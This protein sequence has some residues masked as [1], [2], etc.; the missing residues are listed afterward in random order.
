MKRSL[1]ALVFGAAAITSACT[2][3]Q[4]YQRPAVPAP[5][6]WKTEAPWQVAAPKDGI[7][8]GAWWQTFQ[9][10]E[11]NGYEQQL[12]QANQSLAAAR[13][14]LDQAR[15]FAKV[16]SSGLFPQLSG[17]V[18]ANRQRLSGNRPAL[19]PGAVVTPVTGNIFEIPFSLNYEAD[20]FGGIRRNLA[21]ANAQLQAN[22]ADLQ[23]VQ[24][25]LTAE[26]AADY[27]SLRE[28]D[29]ETDVVRRSVADEERALQLVQN[30]HSGGIA[31]GLEVAQQ[32][33]LLDSTRTQLA[34]VQQ[35]R[36]QF[37]H[38]MAVLTGNPAPTFSVP[39]KPL[40]AIPPAIPVGV[41]SVL[42]E[43]RPDIAT[44]E[45]LMAAQN[46]QVG[47]ATA[48]FYPRIALG[49]TGGYESTDITS[50]LNAPS[51]FWSI[52]TNLLQ[53]ILNG[54]RN[55]ANLAAAKAGYNESVAN[56]RQSVLIA[57]Q[58]VEDGISGLNALSQAAK[59]QQAA[60]DDSR[61]SLEIANNRYVGGVTT[62]LDVVTA[63]SSLLQNERL[64]T[65]LLGQQMLTSVYL[66]KALGG[67]WDSSE[68]QNQVVRP[69]AGQALQP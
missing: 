67:G 14:R 13:S 16:A 11:L 69:T 35:Q 18:S 51:A 21:S 55:R 34:L 40:A 58:Q 38:A 49:G 47:V 43:R 42:L 17:G 45:R 24:L 41:P 5:P 19:A 25:V 44:A 2:V 48:A 64:A 54:G 57:F 30:R 22:A 33:A 39:A 10:E 31:S 4:K 7:P 46:E 37:E 53:P 68:I 23:N 26:L 20:L 8:K 56:Y 59:T 32:A 12:L 28:L 1:A 36:A 27:F 50:L 9:D 61:R 15:A 62:Y 60:V 3:G 29:A 52:G 66:V 6:S 65:Q 63:E